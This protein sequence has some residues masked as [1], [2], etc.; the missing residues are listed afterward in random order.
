M[1]PLFLLLSSN[2][3]CQFYKHIFTF[4]SISDSA[5]C[6]NSASQKPRKM[7]RTWFFFNCG[8]GM[9]INNQKLIIF[10]LVTNKYSRILKTLFQRKCRFLNWFIESLNRYFGQKEDT[11]HMGHIGRE[12]R[13]N[14]THS[15]VTLN[16][17]F[18][19]M[20]KL[21]PRYQ[22]RLLWEL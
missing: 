7:A 1:P 12:L 9:F 20:G 6:S 19:Q 15:V 2:K 11:L 14:G 8:K 10:I 4:F 21:T 17:L 22:E 13:A 18:V 16:V 3:N 5:P